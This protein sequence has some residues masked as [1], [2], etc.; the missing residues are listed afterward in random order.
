ME[1]KERYNNQ[2]EC[3]TEVITIFDD[4]SYKDED[5]DKKARIVTLMNK[6]SS[7]I[8]VYDFC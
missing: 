1:D 4:P 7:P 8:V 5:A 3:V 2:L 6:V